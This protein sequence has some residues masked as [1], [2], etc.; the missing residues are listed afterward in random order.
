MYER[1][2]K[3]LHELEAEE[4]ITILYAAESGSRTHGYSN[5][6][7]DYDIKFIYK[8][9]DI[10]RYLVLDSFKDVILE[11]DGLLDLMGWDI[12]KALNLHYKSNAGLMECMSSPMVYVPDEIEM[13][14]GLPEFSPVTLRNQYYGQA[15]KTN[16]KYI[17][18]SDL[19]D[20]KIVKKT[21]YVIRCNRTWMELSENPPQVSDEVNQAISNITQ[22][23]KNLALDEITDNDLDLV[24]TWINESLDNYSF[25]KPKSKSAKRDIE[26]YNVRFQEIIGVR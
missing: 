14:R 22:A 5:D 26:E 21:L 6:D 16:R 25:E 15:L 8:H 12:K 13:F 1:I 17:L 11:E 3:K 10:S 19:R 23:Y 7:S 24:H 20:K 18:K 4:N 9:N 2:L